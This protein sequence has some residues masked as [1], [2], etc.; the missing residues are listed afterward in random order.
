M[1]HPCDPLVDLPQN[2]INELLPPSKPLVGV[3]TVVATPREAG[4]GVA[5]TVATPTV[6]VEAHG[7]LV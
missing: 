2:Q 1:N 5:T 4:R 7:L 3:A 6:A